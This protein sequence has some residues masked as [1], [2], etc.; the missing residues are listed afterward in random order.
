MNNE[1]AS[2]FRLRMDTRDTLIQT[3][4]LKRRDRKKVISISGEAIDTG[5]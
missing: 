2:V 3:G 5:C 4:N 1:R